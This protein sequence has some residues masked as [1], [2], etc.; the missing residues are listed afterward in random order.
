MCSSDLHFQIDF[1]KLSAAVNPHT[2]AVII[3]SPNNPSGTVYSEETIK[4]LSSLLEEKS[5]QYNHPIFII[6][7]EPYR[8][9]VYDGIQI[10]F[11]TKYYRNTFVCYSYSKSLSL[12]GERIGYIVVPSELEN[13]K[14]AYAAVCGAGRSL[15]YVNAPSL[16]QRVAAICADQTSDISIYERNRNLLYNGLS[17]LGFSCVKPQGAFYI[18]PRSLEPDAAAFCERAKKYDLLLVPGDDFGCPGHV[19]ISYCVPTRRIERAMDLFA[20]LAAEYQ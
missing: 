13:A 19:R 16:F 7:D 10:P 6:S 9:L 14:T 4:T 1:D 15:G 17:D 18:F 8:E 5:R 3:N 11:I 12:P 2:K 20:K